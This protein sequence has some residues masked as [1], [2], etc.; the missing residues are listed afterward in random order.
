[1]NNKKIRTK[2]EMEEY[3]I[4][5]DD[6]KYIYN[7]NYY[8]KNKEAILAKRREKYHYKKHHQS[9]LSA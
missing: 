1:M 5:L 6:E 8:Q 9:N 3:L 7:K 4:R 2:A